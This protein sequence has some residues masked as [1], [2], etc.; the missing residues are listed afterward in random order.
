MLPMR[1]S[2]KWSVNEMKDRAQYLLKEVGLES[3]THR[4]ANQLSGGEQQR[5]AVA[6]SLSN[7]PRIV[8]ADEP[9]GNLDTKNSHLVFD[10]MKKI[11]HEKDGPAMLVVTHN[12]TIAEAS[13]VVLRMED[14][15][16]I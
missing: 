2:G 4:K 3:K 9:T 13:D 5:V 12:P 11:A 15:Q 8:L 1:K 14:G 7:F 16:F 6:R 10:L